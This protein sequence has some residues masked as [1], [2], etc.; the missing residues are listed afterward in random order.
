MTLHQ[1]RGPSLS[2][3]EPMV[4]HDTLHFEA[5][6]VARRVA[7]GETGSPLRPWADTVT[8]LEVMDRVRSAT[9]LDF[10]GSGYA[11]VVHRN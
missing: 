10:E 8:T 4:G 2:W 3:A 11:V 9:G 5:A 1:R 6:E 7:A